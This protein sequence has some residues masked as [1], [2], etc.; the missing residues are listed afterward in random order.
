MNSVRRSLPPKLT[1]AVHRSGTENPL[2]LTAVRPTTVTPSPVKEEIPV[3]VERHA[4]RAAIRDERLARQA[5]I[6]RNVVAV[7]LSRTMVGDI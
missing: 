7:R 4:V 5:A 1:F 6:G 3:G 2:D